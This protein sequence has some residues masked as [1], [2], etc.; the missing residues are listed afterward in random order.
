M[1]FNRIQRTHFVTAK[2]MIDFQSIRI[3]SKNELSSVSQCIAHTINTLSIWHEK[4]KCQENEKEKDNR[5]ARQKK[6][7][8][9]II[10]QQTAYLDMKSASLQKKLFIAFNSTL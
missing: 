3:C 7:M 10:N 5:E 2:N 6:N 1:N 9:I 8:K 4:K